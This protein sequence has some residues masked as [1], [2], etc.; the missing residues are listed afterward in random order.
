[1]SEPENDQG[2]EGLRFDR[3][4]LNLLYGEPGAPGGYFIGGVGAEGAR[5]STDGGGFTGSLG[6]RGL[7]SRFNLWGS[8]RL[9]LGG[10]A[11]QAQ[12][13]YSHGDTRVTSSFGFGAPH[14]LGFG[15]SQG[16]G[17]GTTLSREASFNL[18]A[19]S[20]DNRFKLT[21]PNGSYGFNQS[22]GPDGEKVGLDF[23]RR[24]DGGSFSG[25][26]TAGDAIEGFSLGAAQSFGGGNSLSE[27]FGMTFGDGG[28][29]WSLGLGSRLSP[30]PR[31]SFGTDLGLK[32]GPD[33]YDINAKGTQGF[34]SDPFAQSLW[35]QGSSNSQTGENFNVGGSATAQLLPNLY[36]SA[37]GSYGDSSGGDP[38]WFAGGAMTYMPTSQLGLTAAGGYGSDGWE[39]RLQ[40][41]FFKKGVR[42]AGGLEDQRNKALISGYLGVS[43][44]GGERMNDFFGAPDASRSFPGAG[45]PTFSLG[46]G[47]GF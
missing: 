11:K 17:D 8:D 16:M 12:L 29:A 13:G 15:V 2:S 25:A 39:S 35:A 44:G 14:P 26:F 20:I 41:D 22:Y 27:R 5:W 9:T 36:G 1:M 30:H 7:D 6:Q 19:A 10:D 24:Y 32:L 43:G 23:N 46:L 18:G 34:R 21:D 4:A 33:G 37:Y 42:G 45:G 31:L 28:P 40:A 38:S 3:R 47:I